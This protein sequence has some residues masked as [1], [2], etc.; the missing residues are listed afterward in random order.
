MTVLPPVETFVHEPLAFFSHWTASRE[1]GTATAVVDCNRI[2]NAPLAI[3]APTSSGVIA[4]VQRSEGGCT[5][6]GPCSS[7]NWYAA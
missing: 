5:G 1:A 3:A 2:R 4:G 6:L 7:K